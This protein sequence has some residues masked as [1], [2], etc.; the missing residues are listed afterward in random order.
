[1]MHNKNELGKTVLRRRMLL[2][3]GAT[4]IVAIGGGVILLSKPTP[5]LAQEVVVYKDPSCGC[6]SQWVKHLRRSGFSVVVNNVEDMEPIKRKAGIPDAME[7]CHTAYVGDY[8]IEGHVP[9]SDIKRMLAENLAIKGLAVPGMPSSA[10]GMDD[11]D[12]EPYSVFAF[13]TNG[14]TSVFASY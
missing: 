13:N 12:Y 5:T 9:A 1:M 6:C 10:P 2:A 7:S 14:A 8:S 11:P 3:T 4:A